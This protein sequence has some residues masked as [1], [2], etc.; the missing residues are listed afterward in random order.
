MKT[1]KVQ[2]IHVEEVPYAVSVRSTE[3][4]IGD[5]VVE[6]LTNGKFDLFQIDTANDIDRKRQ[7]KIIAFPYQ[8]KYNW[9]EG[10]CLHDHAHSLFENGTIE[11]IYD[12]SNTLKNGSR[13]EILLEGCP[14]VIENGRESCKCKL[15]QMYPGSDAS[16]ACDSECYMP[17]PK[18]IEGKVILKF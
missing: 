6:K 2:I 15:E 5:F 10:H 7:R 11:D 1:Q 18:L 14:I 4:H 16:L 3:H 13:C 9:V 17:G 12:R 8:L